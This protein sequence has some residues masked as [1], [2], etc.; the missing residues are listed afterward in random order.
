VWNFLNDKKCDRSV[1]PLSAKKHE[2][3]HGKSGKLL[4]HLSRAKCGMKEV[5]F[6]VVLF[7]LP[8]VYNI[9]V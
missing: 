5:C 6:F 9:N 1:A 7:V 2:T 8:G 4:S 3:V